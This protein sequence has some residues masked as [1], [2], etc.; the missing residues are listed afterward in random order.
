MPDYLSPHLDIKN[1]K[2]MEFVCSVCEKLYFC[3]C[4]RAAMEAWYEEAQAA[5]ANYA[6][7]GWPQLHAPL[8][9]NHRRSVR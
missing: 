1:K 8:P 4:F 9:P 2:L 6:S 7:D 5:R 3:E